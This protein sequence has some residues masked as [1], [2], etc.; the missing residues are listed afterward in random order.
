M[1]PAFA[2]VSGQEIAA[3]LETLAAELA[4]EAS[5]LDLLVKIIDET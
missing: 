2:R 5:K 1:F 4:E 3:E